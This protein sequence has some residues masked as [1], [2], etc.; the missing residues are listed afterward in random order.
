[1][2]LIDKHRFFYRLIYLLRFVKLKT[3]NTCMKIYQ[4]NHFTILFTSINTIPIIF[5]K[6]FD[7]IFW[8]CINYWSVYN[9]S[10][11][12]KYLLLLISGFLDQLKIAKQFMQLELTSTNYWNKN[13]YFNKKIKIINIQYY[14]LDNL[15]L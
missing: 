13:Q 14:C 12:N 10:I 1:M 7:K 4:A 15:I 8:W 6:K 9:F 2:K 11:K 5:L 3:L